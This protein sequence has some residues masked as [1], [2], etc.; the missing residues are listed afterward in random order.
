MDNN[1]QLTEMSLRYLNT[2]RKW[3]MFFA[4]LGFIG[5]GFMFV[6][7]FIMIL[8][9]F[10]AEAMTSNGDLPFPVGAGFGAIGIFYFILGAI[11][12]I[13]SVYLLKFSNSAK[14]LY[15]YR[16]QDSV[17]ETFRHLKSYYKLYGILTIAIFGL[18][19]IGIV[20]F[21]LFFAGSAM[22]H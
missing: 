19:I 14:K 16:K 1:L 4:I 18:Y 21:M 20:G 10:A 22:L 9:T 11:I 3:T 17:D 15:V 8:S 5:A 12:I 2:T 13:P 6:A 7:G